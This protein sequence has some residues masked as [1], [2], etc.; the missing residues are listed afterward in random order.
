MTTTV[1][2]IEVLSAKN[3]QVTARAHIKD[4]R[5]IWLHSAYD[6]GREAV[7]L[8]SKHSLI[9]AGVIIV[10]GLGLGHHVVEVLRR[11]GERT[12]VLVV[13]RN[14][15]MKQL[16]QRHNRS[17]VWERF[18]VA[19]NEQ[20]IKAFLY[21]HKDCL[22]GQELVVIEHTASLQLDLHYYG[23]MRK[24]I[25]DYVSTLVVELATGKNLNRFIHE[26]VFANLPGIIHDPGITA[27]TD[28][29]KGKPA[30]IVAAGPSLNKNICLLAEA[31]NKS[32]VICVG[33]ALRAMLA[34]GLHPDFVVTLDPMEANYRLFTG[35]DPT[36]AFLCYEPQT[37]PRIPPLFA[38]RRFVFNSF[39]NPLQLWL[40]SLYGSKGYVEP[41]GSVAIAAFGI[42]LILGCNP[43][44]FV[45][46][47]LAYT[48][49]FSHAAGTVYEGRRVQALEGRL[50]HL[51]VPAI[52]GGKV[53]TS[54]AMHGFLVRFEE[55]FALHNDRLIIDATEGGAL[56]RGT[57][58]MTFREA[59]DTYFTEEVPALEIIA[60]K[61]REASQPRPEVSARVREELETTLE[62][63]RAWLPLLEEVV[64][65]AQGIVDLAR[66][67]HVTPED[68]SGDRFAAGSAR[69]LQEEAARLNALLKQ[70]NAGAKLIDLLSLLTFDVHLAKGP[71]DEARLLEQV[72]HILKLY[73]SY[74]SATKTMIGQLQKTLAT[75]EMP[76]ANPVLEGAVN[77]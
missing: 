30:V 3:G 55:L 61:H 51:E 28:I 47:D 26:N 48:G 58:V 56:K 69:H 44:V 53:W 7:S 5:T 10:L 19:S 45:G 38:K 2:T 15:E 24:R 35:L 22:K 59:L 77:Q 76:E 12:P 31:K 70:A 63:Y 65:T 54:R 1:P 25:R 29:F 64:S 66:V 57:K 20:E 74:Q 17:L 73:G 72:Q 21:R 32:A 43:I 75:L 13:E 49:G 46:Q 71:G 37:H 67:L 9:R 34:E 42:G 16:A 27:I 40:S 11:I 39:G 62:E 4:V 18:T 33:T 6:P 8:V 36:E 50:D 14:N 52:N 60:A 68:A 23:E 41:G